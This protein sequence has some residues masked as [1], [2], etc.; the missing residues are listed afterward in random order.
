MV[1]QSKGGVCLIVKGHKEL[2]E[3]VT[4]LNCIQ[5]EMPEEMK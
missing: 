4:A 1:M 5:T 2:K 3:I